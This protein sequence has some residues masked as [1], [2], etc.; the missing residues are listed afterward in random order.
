LKHRGPLIS[1]AKALREPWQVARICT[2]AYTVVARMV[3]KLPQDAFECHGSDL[4]GI[5]SA[6]MP[7]NLLEDICIAQ[8]G[9]SRD[10][11]AAGLPWSCR[12]HGSTTPYIAGQ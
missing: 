3:T 2:A 4:H 12:M 6:E 9:L 8:Q 5:M 1:W 7:D 10:G 11:D